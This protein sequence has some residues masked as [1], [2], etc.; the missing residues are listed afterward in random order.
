[1]PQ[2][3]E[4]YHATYCRLETASEDTTCKV[5]ADAIAIGLELT[6]SVEHYV[7]ARGKDCVRGVVT[8]PIQ[9]VVGWLPANHSRV[10]CD[11]AEQGWT[12]RI[13][14]SAVGFHERDRS[15]WIEAAVFAYQPEDELAG[16]L[17]AFVTGVMERLGKGE[18][19]DIRLSDG[20]VDA[21]LK[22]NA[23]YKAVKNTSYPKLP[24]GDAYYKRHRTQS[25]AMIMAGS[26]R[27]PGCIVGTIVFYVAVI[28]AATF[29]VW[30]FILG[31]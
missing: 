20:Q 3:F 29:F 19:P 13:A 25:E 4:R 14:A 31:N 7:N 11:L 10:F 21:A 17:G 2:V 24:K 18:R 8:N 23:Y 5:N 26:A 27:K 9:Q 15:Y 6:L 22:D 1:M 28:A 12:V 16:P 30:K